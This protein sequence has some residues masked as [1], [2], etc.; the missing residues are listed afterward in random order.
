MSNKK[1]F[2]I[3]QMLFIIML[4]LA[5]CSNGVKDNLETTDRMFITIATANT[6]GVYF[7][8][9]GAIAKVVEEKL[10]H[11]VTFQSTGGSVEN[12]YLIN[13][14]KAELAFVMADAAVQ[15]YQGEGPFADL[16]EL[17]DLR[18]MAVLYPNYLQVVTIEE[19]GISSIADLEGK[20]V[21]VG[22]PNSGVELN[23][24]KILAT[25]GL[26]YD[27]LTVDYFS[28][29]EAVEQL[30]NGIVEA[31]FI[32]SGIPIPSIMDLSA[33]HNV[34]LIQINE[35]QVEK[36]INEYPFFAKGVIPAGTYENEEDINT[37]VITNL[38]LINKDV[39]DDVAY[40][41][42]R[43]IFE[44]ISSIQNAHDAAREISLDT[45]LEGLVI[46][47]HPGVERYYKEVGAIE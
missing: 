46:P 32:N 25:Y 44:N 45:A 2:L 47:L 21:S 29:S 24:R 15:A 1:I 3:G 6:S 13:S 36:L 39:S 31:A 5:G 35:P 42:T 27:D 40:D 19:T 33:T 11:K 38:L 12:I 14:G 26:T 28:F 10:D 23:A 4:S 18:A 43:V 16:G 20:R 30:K 37:M 17:K 22:S 7:P 8:I 9:G 41:I 34:K